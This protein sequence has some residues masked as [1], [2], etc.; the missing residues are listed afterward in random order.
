MDTKL[1]KVLT[2]LKKLL[3]LTRFMMEGEMGDGAKR[4]PT[5]F[6]P[7]T[8]TNV[9]VSPQNCLA[10]SFNPFATLV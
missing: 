1:Y 3:P 6:A 7:V 8:S 4:P 9:G 2:Y 10:F 5:I